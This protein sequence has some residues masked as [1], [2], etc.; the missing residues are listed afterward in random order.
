MFHPLIP[1]NPS[2]PDEWSSMPT[3]LWRKKTCNQTLCLPSPTLAGICRVTS[4]EVPSDR[5]PGGHVQQQGTTVVTCTQCTG[6]PGLPYLI[7]TNWAAYDNSNVFS[8]SSGGQKPGINVQAGFAPLCELGGT[9]CSLPLRPYD[10]SQNPGVPW[11]VGTLLQSL[12]PSSRGTL[13]SLRFCFHI[14]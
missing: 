13:F 14:S 8:H 3:A 2:R 1:T 9:I 10:G 7:G 4:S 12:M 6:S 11:L 5:C